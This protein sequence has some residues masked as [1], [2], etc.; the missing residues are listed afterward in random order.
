MLRNINS[1]PFELNREIGRLLPR[2][3]ICVLTRIV[4]GVALEILGKQDF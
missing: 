1:R 3:T 2:S 4:M